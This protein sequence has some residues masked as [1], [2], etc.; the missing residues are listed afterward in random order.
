LST[1]S[2]LKNIILDSLFPVFCLSCQK[3]GFWLCEKCLAET[4]ILDF[5]VCPACE[6]VIT[7][8]GFLCYFC[9][10]T[11]KSRLDGLIAAVS[12][13]D[14]VARKM[15]HNF[16]YR[17]IGDISESLAEL[18]FRALV[19]NDIALPDFVVPVPLHPKRLRWRG[20]NQ[21]LLLAQHI[22]KEISPMMEIDILDILQ[23]K[24]Y[25]APQMNVKNYRERLENVKNIFGLKSDIN[26]DLVK[27]KNILLIDDIATTGATLEECAKVLKLAGAK[28]VFA[29]V[30]ARQTLKK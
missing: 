16:K 12:Y 27:N 15:V 4:K 23:R 1:A 3:E 11:R 9:R 14:P 8:K 13:D 21:S 22:S 25:N 7:D 24:Y 26:F 2:F 6:E 28:K 17:F 30:V 20:F 10:E 5:Q 19:R 29:A 18:I